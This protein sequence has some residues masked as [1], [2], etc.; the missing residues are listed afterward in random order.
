MRESSSH[1]VDQ[2]IYDFKSSRYNLNL[3]LEFF[4]EFFK[5]EAENG[6]L[7][8]QTDEFAALRELAKK[9]ALTFGPDPLKNREAVASLHK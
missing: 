3:K 4:T 2:S 8:P 9:F 7:D 6:V 5:E 1:R